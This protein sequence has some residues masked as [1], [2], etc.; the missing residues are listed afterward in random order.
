[1][2][3]FEVTPHPGRRPADE[4][5]ALLADPGFGRVFTDHMV[6]VRHSTAKGWYE[7]RLEPFG[8]ISLS[9]ATAAL[10][11]AQEIFEGL[12]AYARPDGGVALF[13]PDANAR[14]FNVTAARMAMPTLP[15]EL[16][17]RA[18]WT[19]VAADH[20]W[21][22]TRPGDS[23]YLRPFMFAT[24]PF[25]G[26][27]PS[28]EY[29]FMV[30]ASPSGAYFA[31]GA[32]PVTV[33]VTRDY[34][35]AAP[36]GTGAVKVAANYGVSLLAQ[37]DALAN[38]CDQVVY[39]DSTEHRFVEESGS[40]NLFFVYEGQLITPPLGGTILPGITR[41]SIVRLAA[42][43]GLEVIERPY[44]IEEWR[45]DAAN[46]RLREVFASGT[47]VVV[48]AIGRVRSAEGEFTVAGGEEGPITSALRQ[49][50]VDIQF[51]RAPDPY[52]WVA[53]RSSVELGRRG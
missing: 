33:W 40:M 42:D 20:E 1:M 31:G 6:S 48:T 50:L 10:H 22:P 8:P 43:R 46:G 7:A 16:F 25:L 23:L 21:V 34:I 3:D 14:R 9:P 52:G 30:I 41:D 39:L 49:S 12:K 51:G 24:D 29:R 38:G 47:G 45:A 28:S 19:L 15:E 18:L 11:Y 13:R 17:V 53:V 37:A 4:R 27:R 26:V 36:G 35:R 2:L 5:A 44:A 32:K